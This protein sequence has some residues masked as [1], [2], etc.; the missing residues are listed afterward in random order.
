MDSRIAIA[1]TKVVV[2][3]LVDVPPPMPPR[4]AP[5]VSTFRFREFKPKEGYTR[6][7]NWR[8]LRVMVVRGHEY[9]ENITDDISTDMFD[10]ISDDMYDEISGEIFGE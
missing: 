8:M 2:H 9:R 5:L 10:D 7:V 3:V 4:C 1:S 6:Y